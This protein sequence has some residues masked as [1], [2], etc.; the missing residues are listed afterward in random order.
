MKKLKNKFISLSCII[1]LIA[2]FTSCMESE[3][4]KTLKSS[5]FV[6]R[7]LIKDTETIKHASGSF[8]LIGGGYHQS[9]YKRT[10]VQVFAKVNDR[11]RLIEMPIEDVRI[12]IDNKLKTPT[13]Q[14]EY[15][16]RDRVEDDELLSTSW[17]SKLYVINCPEQY[18]PEKLL[19]IEI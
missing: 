5:E 1:L 19:P 18:L 7:Q 14:V 17:I 9:E 12:S 3:K 13:V 16:R 15:E 11:Y 8:F 4:H 2:V 6:L 10:Y